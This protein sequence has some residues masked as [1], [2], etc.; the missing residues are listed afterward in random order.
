MAFLALVSWLGHGILC[1]A[2]SAAP[3]YFIHVWQVENGLP[4]NS[5]TAVV[6]TRDGYVW[7]GT[8][9]GLARFDGVRFVVFD[10]INTPGM[11][12]SRV[13]SLFESNDGTLW[14]GYESGEVTRYRNGR[15]EAV[16]VNDIWGHRKILGIAADETGDLWLVNADGLLM[17][18]KD[19]LALSQPVGNRR[20]LPGM[21]KD[22][23]GAIWVIL[24]GKV[25]V[26]R[27][28]KLTPLKLDP[29]PNEGYVQ[30]I[31]P[32]QDRRLWA[33]D[34]GLVG[35]WDGKQW[36]EGRVP[37]PWRLTPLTSLLETRA[38][39]LAAGTQ[40]QGLYLLFSGGE[41]LHFTRT[42][43]LPSDWVQDLCEDQEGNL[44]VATSGG[45][46]M[47]KA[48][49]LSTLS[50]PDQWQARPILSVDSGSDGSLWVGTEGAG[51]YRWK[52]KEWSHFGLPEGVTNLYVW[53]I[54]ED[55]Q[56]R[57]WLGTWGGGLVVQSGD[58][59]ERAPGLDPV[60]P[61]PAMFLAQDEE[62]WIGTGAGLLRRQGGKMS[63]AAKADELAEPDV[64]AVVKDDEGAVWFGMLGGGLGC[65]KDG[66][67]RQFRKTDGLSSDFVQCLRLE[68]DGALWIGTFGGGLNR[69][70]QGRFSCINK[71]RGLPNDVIC[72]MEE[73]GQ[74]FYWISSHGGIMRVS[75]AELN[76]CADGLIPAVRCQSYG[77]GDGMPTTECSGGLQ[78][79]GCK[80]ADGRLWFPTSK[81]LVVVDPRNVKT[82]PTPPPVVLEKLLIDDRVA[83]A[84]AAL[85][86]PPQI[87]PGRHQFEFQYTGLSFVD[88]EE[89]R[90]KYRLGGLETEWREAGNKRTANYSYIP[91]GHYTFQ[92]IACNNDGVWNETGTSLTFAVLPLFWQ[93]LWFRLLAGGLML[94]AAGGIVWYDTRRRMGR[95]LERVE[96][97][98]A[99]ERERAR[100]AQDIHD[101]LGTHLTRITMMSE[102]LRGELNN[103][104]EAEADLGQI[105]DTARELTRAMDEI[106]WAVNPKHDT[107]ESLVNY[108]E[109]FAQDFLGAAGIRFR[110]DVPVQIPAWPLTAEVR[111]NLF[112]AFKETL[113]NIVKHASAS[114]T[115]VS[116]VL[117]KPEAFELSV[118]DD[119]CG[120]TYAG[121]V[122]RAREVPGR[123]AS[124]D[125]LQNMVRRLSEI[126]GHCDIT[127][128][129]GGGTKV[130]F[131]VPLTNRAA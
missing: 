126:G 1:A 89:V 97:Q 12:S 9:S 67:L 42:N 47:L 57:V 72:D 121:G 73:D 53:S 86:P 51:L 117:A 100:I 130:V 49:C 46:A 7:A 61:A 82:N 45:L 43:G 22:S 91:P 129:P 104:Q 118:E 76:R 32:G 38:G 84:G 116:L 60:V 14:I 105:Y 39:V 16:P 64:R 103:P 81:G 127:S 70:K 35:K 66:K 55:A 63:W 114:E 85:S 68:D 11:R 107:M 40:D 75:K 98:R 26:L 3:N 17:R 93:S 69:L 29:D 112:L 44:W 30:G 25:S 94:A 13:T 115:R 101:D 56:R 58:H 59:F 71:S 111:H 123:F 78:P 37:A 27:R 24:D 50:P 21:A 83:F 113:N 31:C 20:G 95:E 119:G 92:V 124:G 125:G 4:Q 52:D 8:Y 15:F 106:V 77:M 110:L 88:P 90:F 33:V 79:A 74:G 18:L 5:V 62:L 6:Q 54:C 102:S 36:M 65:L 99:V 109:K 34:N 28:A 87:S 48:S 131:N 120:F 23:R 2:V 96:R 10:S 19:G 41:I 122:G 108:L 128:T 80:T